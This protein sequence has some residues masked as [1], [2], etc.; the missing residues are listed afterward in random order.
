[1]P[2]SMLDWQWNLHYPTRQD[3]EGGVASMHEKWWAPSDEEGLGAYLRSWRWRMEG[4][5]EGVEEERKR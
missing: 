2:W 4:F 1:M 5:W 3:L